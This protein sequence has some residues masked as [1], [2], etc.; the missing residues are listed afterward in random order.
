MSTGAIGGVDMLKSLAASGTLRSV[1]LRST[2]R[3][4]ALVQPWMDARRVDEI[5][6]AQT[7]L[8]VFSGSAREA[9]RKFAT[10]ANVAAV[11]GLASLGLD[12]VEVE[13]LADPAASAKRHEIEAVSDQTRCTFIVENAFSA[14]NPRT[15]AITPY[16]ALRMIAD[17]ID[18]IVPGV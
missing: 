11:V 12:D 14:A 13:I 3:P 5:L 4:A 10:I 7:T 16:A 9:S 8:S 18:A 15:S 6:G 17:R 2:T 1:H